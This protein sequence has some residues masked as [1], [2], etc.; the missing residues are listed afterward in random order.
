M[1][2]FVFRLER[3]L[4]LREAEAKRAK[5]AAANA[6][7]VAFGRK[8]ELDQATGTVCRAEDQL[9]LAGGAI[10]RG[11]D[12]AV[13]SVYLGRTRTDAAQARAGLEQAYAVQAQAVT[14]ARQA[15][16]A[17]EALSNLRARR[18][19]AWETE[20]IGLLQREIDDLSAGRTRQDGRVGR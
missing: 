17:A 6:A 18:R 12:L 1:A 7:A 4:A 3:L 19:R 15:W 11:G 13:A 8:Q 5:S 9:R 2:R 20:E 16:G 14:L 10:S